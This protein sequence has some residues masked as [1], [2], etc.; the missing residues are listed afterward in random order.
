MTQPGSFHVRLSD[1]AGP[2]R[3]VDAAGAEEAAMLFLEHWAPPDAEA[4]EVRLIVTG[5][6]GLSCCLV[7]DLIIHRGK[8]C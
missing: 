8:P 1:Q 7:V 6:A 2:G 3:L 4:Q 5:E